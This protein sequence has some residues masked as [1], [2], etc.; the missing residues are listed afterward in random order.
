[1]QIKLFPD[2]PNLLGRKQ[3]FVGS[4]IGPALYVTGGDVVTL[5]G[6]NTYIDA[7]ND[8]VSLSG[9]YNL[10]AIPSIAGPRAVWKLQWI[11]F[12]TG[13]EVAA[14]TVLSGESAVVNGFASGT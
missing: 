2:W 3:A 8:S 5:T 4:G 1:M 9:T 14:N 12:A 10:R 11:V 13:L 7:L 6:Y